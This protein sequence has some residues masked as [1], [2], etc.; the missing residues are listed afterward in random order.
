MNLTKFKKI[1]KSLVSCILGSSLL[2]GMGGANK[3]AR[4][5]FTPEQYTDINNE[6]GRLPNLYRQEI[7]DKSRTLLNELRTTFLDNKS[8]ESKDF[9]KLL[10]KELDEV[11]MSYENLDDDSL[12]HPSSK[13]I[14]GQIVFLE[15][16]TEIISEKKSAWSAHKTFEKLRLIVRDFPVTLQQSLID[17]LIEKVD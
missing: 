16:F 3:S 17:N 4:A 10:E 7:R 13:Q 6:I 1:K 9:Q 8:L 2:L 5:Y 15:L 11:R 12:K 14:L